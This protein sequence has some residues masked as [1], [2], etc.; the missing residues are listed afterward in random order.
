M[1]GRYTNAVTWKDVWAFSQPLTVRTPDEDP[2]PAYNIAPTQTGWVIRDDEDGQ[3]TALQMKWGLLPPWAKDGKIAFSTFNARLDTI[4]TKPAFRSAWKAGR[5]CLVVASGFYEWPVVDGLKRPHFIHRTDSPVMLFA[6]LWER[7]GDTLSYTIVT[8]DPDDN[9][10][11]MHDRM[12]L[13]LPP[14]VLA[15]WLRA[16]PGAAMDLAMSVPE[17]PLA[18][19]EVGKA[20]GN[21]RNQG[22]EL[23]QPLT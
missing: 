9:I 22:P 20:V 3:A 23:M 7:A 18:F 5:R 2:A 21:V 12:P 14:E 10:T 16:P 13:I 8:R 6:G 11:D 1:C 4:A 17:Q 19:Y 15:D